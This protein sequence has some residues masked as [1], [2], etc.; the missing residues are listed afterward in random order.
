MIERHYKCN[1]CRDEK[2]VEE[3]IGVHYRS[4]NSGDFNEADVRGVENH[5]CH[6]CAITIAKIVASHEK[7]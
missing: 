1:F 7:G 4:N 2:R 5:I 3:L 6:C